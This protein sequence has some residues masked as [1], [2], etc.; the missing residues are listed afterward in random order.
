[1]AV[2]FSGA[3][4]Q[5]CTRLGGEDGSGVVVDLNSVI[6]FELVIINRKKAVMAV[7]NDKML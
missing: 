2:V 1:M 3:C 5:F 7:I 6:E 4:R